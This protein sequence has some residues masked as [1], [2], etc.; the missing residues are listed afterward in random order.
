MSIADTAPPAE[1]MTAEEFLALPDDGIDRE[2]IR[3]ELR[4]RA[5]TVRNRF[6]S[7][8]EA[9]IAHVLDN[10]LDA[11]ARAPGRRSS[12]ARPGSGSAAPETRSSGSTSPTSRP[13]W[14]RTRPRRKA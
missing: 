10:W 13:N 11:A 5:M 1:A 2:L 9:R 7:S 4:E 3:G 14:S 8:T 6:H 12:A